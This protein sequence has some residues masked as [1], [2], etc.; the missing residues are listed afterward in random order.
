MDRDPRPAAGG[1]ASLRELRHGPPRDAGLLALYLNDHLAGATAGV[2]LLR[3]TAHTQ[4][5]RNRRSALAELAGQVERDR[6]ALKR[7]MAVL[8]VPVDRRKVAMGRLAEAAGRMKPNGRL[9]SRS[10]LSDVVE[11]E[12]MLLG[13]R[14]K[15]ACWRAL[16]ALAED[17]R[18]LP[19][20]ELDD[21][22]ERADRQS[23][24]L[25]G[26]RLAAVRSVFHRCAR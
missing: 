15:A 4:A 20:R 3:R 26:M 18:R 13:V 11:L 16:R 5:G 9:L 19:V 23:D 8:G 25:E 12:T 7:I 6:A 21:L 2:A 14:G 1:S 10:P 24:V 22:V 17:D